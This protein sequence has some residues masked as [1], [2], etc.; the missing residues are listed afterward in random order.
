MEEAI[1]REVGIK[2]VQSSD[3]IIQQIQLN[4]QEVVDPLTKNNLLSGVFIKNVQL[5]AGIT[6]IVPTTINRNVIGY[7]VTRLNAGSLI[8]DTQDSNP[9]PTQ[10]LQLMCSVD[11]TVTLYIF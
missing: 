7:L 5:K 10:N 6:N 2:L 3:R 9:T 1:I 4:I 11:V 8:W